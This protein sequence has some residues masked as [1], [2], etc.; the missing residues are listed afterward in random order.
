MVMGCGEVDGVERPQ[1]ST[2]H[3]CRVCEQRLVDVDQIELVQEHVCSRR[4]AS[5]AAARRARN[6]GAHQRR[7]VVVG[8]I[9]EEPTQGH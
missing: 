8:R 6:F 9:R 1:V 4:G 7:R 5:V 2:I 3:L